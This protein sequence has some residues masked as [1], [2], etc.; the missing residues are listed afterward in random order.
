MFAGERVIEDFFGK[1]LPPLFAWREEPGIQEV[2]C[3]TW[4]VVAR[5]DANQGSHH[6][7]TSSSR[8]CFILGTLRERRGIW[9]VGGGHGT[10]LSM[11][12]TTNFCFVEANIK[13]TT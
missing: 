12:E 7:A 5:S 4:N 11:Q 13:Q 9:W 6:D 8:L 1:V 3:G 10:F 2:R